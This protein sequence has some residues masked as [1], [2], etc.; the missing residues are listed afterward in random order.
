MSGEEEEDEDRPYIETPNE[1]DD[2]PEKNGLVCFLNMER[3][4]GPDCMAYTTFASESPHLNEQQK[5][6]TLIVGVERLGRYAGGLLSI[7]KKS[8]A[9][10]RR[11]AS[12]TPPSPRG[13]G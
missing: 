6:C 3:P 1:L 11:A 13:E 10:A 7:L 2:D 4:C 5:H 9:D 8:Q 12:R